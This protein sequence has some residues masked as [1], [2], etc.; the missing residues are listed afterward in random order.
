MGGSRGD[1]GVGA[2]GVGAA[3]GCSDGGLAEAADGV[4]TAGVAAGVVKGEGGVASGA[5]GGAATGVAGRAGASSGG[6]AEGM[7]EGGDGPPGEERLPSMLTEAAGGL[8]TAGVP[9]GVVKGEGGVATGVAGRAG[10]SSGGPAEGLAG[11]PAR[12][13]STG[14]AEGRVTMC[15]RLHVSET[16]CLLVV[17][18]C[19]A[20]HT[21]PVFAGASPQ[22]FSE[23]P[24]SMKSRPL[25][26]S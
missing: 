2:V 16:A 24:D 17:T 1:T 7:T 4:S 9:A 26:D 15:R 14:V 11:E 6:L 19:W 13:V 3:V 22:V 5:V 10:A 25:L 12:G 21:V 23:P 18:P 8:S 20:V